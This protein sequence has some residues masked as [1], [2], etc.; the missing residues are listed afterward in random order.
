M[1]LFRITFLLSFFAGFALLLGCNKAGSDSESA[2]LPDVVD[3]NF[4][5]KPI[6]SDRCFKCHG[7]DP[8]TREANLRLDTQEG[9]LARLH[10]DSTRFSI[11]PGNSDESEVYLRITHPDPEERMPHPDSKMF[12]SDREKEVIK[13]W[14][15]QGAEWKSHWAFEPPQTVEPPAVKQANWPRNELDQFVLARLEQEGIKPS[16]E[17]SPEKWL[18]RVS[19]DLTGLPPTLEELEAFLEDTSPAAYEQAVDRLLASRAYGERMASIWLDAARYADSHGYQDDRPRTMWPWRDWVVDAY[20]QNMPYDQFITW[21]LAGDLLPEATYEQKL[22]TAFNRN[23]G[24]TQEGGVVNEEYVTEYVA[25]RTNTMATTMMGITAECSRCHD[26]KYDPISQK[27]YFQ[28]F[29]FFNTIE[30]RGQIN[31]FDQ[32]PVPNMRVQDA[33]LEAEIARLEEARA[34]AES[35]FKE[36]STPREGFNAWL[37]NDFATVNLPSALRKGLVAHYALDILAG[38]ETP[39]AAQPD[40][41]GKINTRLLNVLAAPVVVSGHDGNAFQFDGENY[42]N[43]G[44][45][46]DF[47][48]ANRFSMGAWIRGAAPD[49]KDAA[50]IVKRNE[51]QKR[52][53]YQLLLTRG[54]RLKAGIIHDQ[55]NERI[56]VISRQAINPSNWTHVFA[57][58][59][60][61]GTAS[62]LKLYVDGVVQPVVVERDSLAWRS[63]L[64]GNDILLGNWTTRNTPHGSLSGYKDG[65]MDEVRIY[66]RELALIEVEA[67]AGGDPMARY[68]SLTEGRRRRMAQEAILPFYLNH[69]GGDFIAV[70]DQLD[71]LRSVQLEVPHIMIMEEMAEP[72]PTHVLARGA[73]DAPTEEVEPSTPESILPFPDDLPRNRLGLAQ[74]LLHPDHPLTS[75]VAVNQI[76][77]T[78]FGRGIVATPED[79]GSQ[80]T[81][82]THPALLDW[83]AVRY[84]GTGWDTKAMMKYIVLSSTYR[85]ASRMTPDAAKRDPQNRLLAR[86]PAQRF[87][88]EMVRDNALRIS[89][90]LKEKDGGPWVK[91]YQPAGV[92]KELANQIGENKYRPS[93]GDDLYRRSLYSYWKRTIPPPAMLTFDAAERTVC[94]VKRQATSTP[95]QALILLNDPMLVEASRKVAERVMGN[96]AEVDGRIAMAFRLATSRD[97]EPEETEILVSLF[98]K[99]HQRFAANKEAA[100][101]LLAVGA[102]QWDKNI[103]PVELAAFAVTINTILNMDE[104]KMRS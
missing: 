13:R 81:L 50:L 4:H 52:G 55:G 32:A 5:V 58:Y 100:L 99:E 103:D 62:G 27:N 104:A 46:G 82:P 24:I 18:R 57:T 35:R 96:A 3:F 95:L 91:P 84:R 44:D 78:L 90:L 33:E 87:S 7:P 93:R 63:I 71:S 21:Q 101:D 42:L 94:S 69:H 68:A 60:G 17:E 56:E 75:R 73:Y 85:Q 89:G 74:W 10:E 80:G 28:L 61:S 53:G 70:R 6:L 59:D 11:V 72:R 26:H 54:N 67:L 16:P 65:A 98:E 39:D 23:H 43:I 9:G 51:E 30:E 40:K 29:A 19:F 15:E 88:A 79:F 20:N 14:I 97:P 86:G 49:E 12:L 77:Q 37:K 1:R 38:N 66:D 2:A 36:L 64:N 83:L 25:D 22:A 48:Q 45:L 47:D 92:W 102:S 41:P 76:W 31:Y 34:E 8:N